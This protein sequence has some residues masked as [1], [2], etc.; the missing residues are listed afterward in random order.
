MRLQFNKIG[1]EMY[2]KE[3]SRRVPAV[4]AK[5]GNPGYGFR[6]A[7]WRD[8][9]VAGE[10]RK[11]C[12]TIFKSLGVSVERVD[13]IKKRVHD[14]KVE[15][16]AVRRPSRPAGP[17]RPR[18]HK[19]GTGE[20]E[21]RDAVP[22]LVVPV[23]Q[24]AA[25]TS[26]KSKKM[27]VVKAKPAYEASINGRS[28]DSS[29][30]QAHLVNPGQ[31]N[32]NA[33]MMAMVEQ[34][35]SSPDDDAR[36]GNSGP[37]NMYHQHHNG[38]QPGQQGQPGVSEGDITVLL[39]D[40]NQ[41]LR[42]LNMSLIYE[43]EQLISQLNH[44]EQEMTELHTDLETMLSHTADDS[45]KSAFSSM[46][47]RISTKGGAEEIDDASKKLLQQA[48]DCFETSARR[49][50]YCPTSPSHDPD[51]FAEINDAP[52]S[53]DDLR[54]FLRTHSGG[55]SSVVK[56]E[57]PSPQVVV[58]E[59]QHKYKLQQQHQQNHHQYHQHQHQVQQDAGKAADRTSVAIKSELGM[60]DDGFG[61]FGSYEYLFSSLH[62]SIHCESS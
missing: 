24:P 30:I 33:P 43:R 5:P 1:Y 11:I 8:T 44:T 37:Y 57:V 20:F 10:D 27:P 46:A 14:F 32:G 29:S 53:C 7:R 15:W 59:Q 47:R 36:Q 58:A 18:G 54:E 19:R 60:C 62:G 51:L 41:S 26:K 45:A 6:R 4:R 12:E 22:A 35:E 28:H 9:C 17:G 25:S 39:G 48:F 55:G 52:Q 61:D 34:W 3:Q 38:M 42:S 2:D 13:R 23:Q 40:E 50:D 16:D 49:R 31:Y 56:K 21:S